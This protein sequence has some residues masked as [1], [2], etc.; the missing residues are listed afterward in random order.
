M[1]RFVA[2]AVAVSFVTAQTAL[3]PEQLTALGSVTTSLRES[4]RCCQ[5]IF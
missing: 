1:I 5:A 3:F 2:L 4:G